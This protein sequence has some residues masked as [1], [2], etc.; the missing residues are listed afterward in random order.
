MM[1]FK[2]K[3]KE[4]Q[5]LQVNDK[6]ILRQVNPEKDLEDYF[7]IYHDAKTFEQYGG[8]RS[9]NKDFIKEK[10]RV[11]AIL[12][13]QINAFE[14]QREYIWTITEIKTDKALG[15]IHFSNFDCNNRVANIGYFINRNY[16]GQG[17]VSACIAPVVNFGFDYLEFERIATKVLPDNIGSWRAL[18]KNGFIREGLLRNCFENGNELKDC[19]LYSKI[20]S[21]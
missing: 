8:T 7:E 19:Y 21:D 15:R 16:W 5:P 11:L 9:L 2:D 13:N 14:K 17:I 18:E 1:A 12:K 4:F 20:Y 10:E 3:F 6:F